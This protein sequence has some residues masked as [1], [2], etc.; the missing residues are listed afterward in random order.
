MDVKADDIPAMCAEADDFETAV[1]IACAS[2]R[3]NG[4]MHSHQTKVT[5][6]ARREFGY[7]ILAHYLIQSRWSPVNYTVP[8]SFHSFHQVLWLL[9]PAGI[10]PLTVYDVA[11]RVG[12]YL[13]LEP[14]RLYL[15]TGARLGWNAL[16]GENARDYRAV[17]EIHPLDWPKPLRQLS[18]DMAEDFLC[19]YRDALARIQRDA[20]G[21]PV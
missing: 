5:K 12:A 18:A 3:R 19:T 7:R 6:D 4:K 1:W 20:R 13:K 15:H 14:D 16:M 9:R 21:R 11:T 10:G 2:K 8:K 17:D